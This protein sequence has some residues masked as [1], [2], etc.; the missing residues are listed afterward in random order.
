MCL[1]WKIWP[2]SISWKNPNNQQ[3]NRSET[4]AKNSHLSS[5]ITVT[6]E[7]QSLSVLGPLYDLTVF[8]LLH[9]I[10]IAA[11]GEISARTY[12]Q[13]EQY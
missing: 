8:K 5:L 1:M 3:W 4:V 2:I 12:L 10:Y 7:L 11:G 6:L 9:V 13:S